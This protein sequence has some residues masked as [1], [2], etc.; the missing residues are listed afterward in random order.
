MAKTNLTAAT[1]LI[2]L[3]IINAQREKGVVVK[4]SQKEHDAACAYAAAETAAHVIAENAKRAELDAN[5][6]L[7]EGTE[8]EMGER[9]IAKYFLTAY[10]CHGF[11][12]NASQFS[13]ALDKL[14]PSDECYVKRADTASDYI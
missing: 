7:P 1:R 11:P 5:G 2:V 6:K 4:W 10:G 12:S 8:L 3:R 9:E 13:Q 14:D